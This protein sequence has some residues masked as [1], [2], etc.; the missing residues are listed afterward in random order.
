M[1]KVENEKESGKLF[2]FEHLGVS[3]FRARG[4]PLQGCQSRI[5]DLV[6]QGLR[7]RVTH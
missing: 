4:S 6:S 3:C 5:G 7:F 2:F 1:E